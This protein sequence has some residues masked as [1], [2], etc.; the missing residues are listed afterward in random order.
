MMQLY[1]CT[2]DVS[3]KVGFVVRYKY[4]LN[5]LG[6]FSGSG[7]TFGSGTGGITASKYW[8]PGYSSN[9][10]FPVSTSANPRGDSMSQV[11]KSNS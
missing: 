8:N 5:L 11:P 10:S 1:T 3:R 6:G 7:S 4:L 2:T 9:I